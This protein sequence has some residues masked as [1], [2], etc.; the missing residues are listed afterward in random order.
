MVGH[1]RGPGKLPMFGVRENPK[2]RPQIRKLGSL[3]SAHLDRGGHVITKKGNNSI[4]LLLSCSL[5]FLSSLAARV[6][7]V[8]TDKIER[9]RKFEM[10]NKPRIFG[11][12]SSSGPR[13][14]LK[15]A[16]KWTEQGN[17]DPQIR[18]KR[19]KN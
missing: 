17:F 2:I 7:N 12:R 8:K 9:I 19:T 3:K 6:A 11:H 18:K 10:S 14:A 1:T 4:F 5:R 16:R 15:S 13:P